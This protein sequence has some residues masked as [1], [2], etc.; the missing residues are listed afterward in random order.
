MEVVRQL[1]IYF[2]WALLFELYEYPK[3]LLLFVKNFKAKSSQ[4][5]DI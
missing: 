4:F 5:S 3:E 1:I 2:R